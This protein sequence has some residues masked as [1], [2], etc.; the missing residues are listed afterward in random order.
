MFKNNTLWVVTQ[1]CLKNNSLEDQ[2]WT[3][4]HGRQKPNLICISLTARMLP[5]L[6]IDN[7]LKQEKCTS[8][9]ELRY[10]MFGNWLIAH[11]NL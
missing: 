2:K 7:V 10:Q 8:W 4:E 1:I 9:E 11:S 3:V 6:F 5:A